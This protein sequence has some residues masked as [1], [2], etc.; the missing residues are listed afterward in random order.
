MA[1]AKA[2][3][4]RKQSRGLTPPSEVI[5]EIERLAETADWSNATT[6]RACLQLA[7]ALHALA[8]LRA[9]APTM[10]K[11]AA[12]GREYII[13]QQAATAMIPALPPEVCEAV[14]QTI[15]LTLE[16]TVEDFEVLL[17]WLMVGVD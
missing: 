17:A 13:K 9:E 15:G 5:E 10:T 11:R 3:Q 6:Y 8:A 1:K 16:P 2:K 7:L 12:I 4:R 14:R